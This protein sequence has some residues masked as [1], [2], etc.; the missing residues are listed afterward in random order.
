[1]AAPPSWSAMPTSGKRRVPAWRNGTDEPDDHRD[2]EVDSAPLADRGQRAIRGAQRRSSGHGVFPSPLTRKLS[3]EFI[4]RIAAEFVSH[5]FGLWALE[6]K[7]TGDFIGFT[8]LSVPRFEAAFHAHGRGRLAARPDAWGNGYA[9]EAARA[10]LR[11]GF[12]RHDLEEIVSFTYEGNMAS[13]A[14]MERLR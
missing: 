14:V 5:G 1:M 8:G 11:E 9:T 7:A 10:S 3:D 6:L 2:R 12:E 13:R 4:D